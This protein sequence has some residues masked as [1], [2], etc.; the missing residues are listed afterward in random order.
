VREEPASI[1]QRMLWLVDHHRGE[2]GALNY[3]VLARMRGPLRAAALAAALEQVAA[4]HETLRTTFARRQGLLTQLI[5]AQVAVPVAERDLAS[6]P[7]PG[8]ALRHALA[9]E[10]GERIDPAA[11]PLRV[12]L[13]RLAP[14]DHVVCLNLHHLVTD[15]W[16]C[17]ILLEDLLQALRGG[18]ALPRVAWQYRHYV[19]W[20]RGQLTADRLRPHRDYW[21][22]RLADLQFS[23][24]PLR[25]H[26]SASPA[27]R[28]GTARALIGG[29]AVA[30]LRRLARDHQTTL[31]TVMLA[32]YYA[33][34]HRVTG[35][36]DVAIASLFANR[37]RAE[38]M[39]TVGFF[40]NLVILRTRFE[41]GA[42]FAS[43]L[44]RAHATVGEARVHQHYPY[45]LLSQEELRAGGRRADEVV[46]QM[47]P[48]IPPPV[49][50]GA[51]EVQVLL[52]EVASRFD[53]ELAVVPRGDSLDV[54]LQYSRGRVDGA[55]AA[56][57]VAEYASL[58][59]DV[60]AA[61]GLRLAG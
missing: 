47:L 19:R 10:I 16:S 8:A 11:T 17:G 2:Q 43:L 33:L 39:R 61:P 50:L 37:T 12:T 59:A 48:E 22:S 45:Y 58:A 24:L 51:V 1:G 20:Q 55:W 53:L 36:T 54:L 29:A 15:A 52:A 9:A 49:V 4:R 21:R 57:F 3:P 44:G 42:T 32:A 40:A 18:A 28:S 7:D 13:W 23:A 31:F 6:A 27:G 25:D 60:V 5:H 14:D 38:V 30:G 41:R 56:G 46:F 35:Q 26:V 34:L